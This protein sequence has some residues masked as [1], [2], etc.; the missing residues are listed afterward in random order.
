MVMTGVIVTLLVGYRPAPTPIMKP[1]FFNSAEDIGAVTLKHFYA[2]LAAENIVILGVPSNRDW[3]TQLVSGFVES[4]AINSRGFTHAVI[5]RQMPAVLRA[6][7]KRLMPT[8]I[9]IDSNTETLSEL[10]DAVLSA[11]KQGHRL[12]VVLPNI[13]STHLL[14]GNTMQRLE[15]NLTRAST[16]AGAAT[17]EGGEANGADEDNG[18]SE[19]DR[20]ARNDVAIGANSLFAISVGPLALEAAQEKELDPVC[21]GSERDGS[22]T[23]EFGCAILQ[24]GRHFYRKR[25]LDKEP[26]ARQRFVAIMQSSKP[27][28]YMLM[29]R[30]PKNYGKK[31]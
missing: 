13:Y 27:G 17:S 5:E 19:I 6:E 29:V 25:I 11:K 22:G 14:L 20:I 10:T 3:S 18:R 8:T 12:L 23:G 1:S 16:G 15:R 24:A 4:A 7:L 21:M 9:E 2:P 28:D 31:L 30:E 26:N